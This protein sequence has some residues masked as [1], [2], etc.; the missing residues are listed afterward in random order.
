MRRT[1]FADLNCSIAQTLEIVGDWWTLLIVRDA[2]LGI[3]R[4]ED[5]VDRLGIARNV[6]TTRLDTLVGAEIFERRPYD[7]GRGRF[8]YL[9]TDKGRALWPVITAMR[10][11]GDEWIFGPGNEP[12]HIEHRD[13]GHRTTAVMTCS[14]CQQRL[15]S[16]SVRAVPTAQA[17]TP[18]STSEVG[19][20]H[21]P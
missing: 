6:L 9:L 10:Q 18:S 19:M 11:W 15:D 12:L 7:E 2:F 3:R 20:P 14:H 16:R 1:S 21:P 8:D 13:C 5:F 4:F 17:E